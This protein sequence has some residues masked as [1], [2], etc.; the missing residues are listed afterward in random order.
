[1]SGKLRCAVVGLGVGEQHAQ[2][3]NAFEST[4]LKV[5]C[6]IDP[7]KREKFRGASFSNFNQIASNENIDLVS[8]ASFDDAHYEQVMACL[9]N[10]KHV[11]VEKPLCRTE[12]ELSNI[13]A[14]WR[15]K[16]TGLASNLVLRKAP[17]F[18]W[19]KEIIQSGGLGE[20]YS[21]DGDY[22]YGRVHKITNEWRSEVKDYSVMAGGGI[23]LIDLMMML[24]RKR[25][26]NVQSCAN[27][28][29]TQGTPFKYPDFHSSTF[30][31]EGSA[32]GRVTANFGC[33]HRHHHVIRVFGTKGTFIYD[34]RGAR[35]HWSR[36]EDS[37]PEKT[38]LNAKPEGKGVLIPDFVKAILENKHESYA[39]REFDLMSVVLA[40]DKALETEKTIEIRYLND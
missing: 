7:K 24:M 17:L 22:L 31:F 37:E 5:V 4:E 38:N 36:D 39:R 40:S 10:K 30:R 16:R 26:V 34:D 28:I 18:V 1:M 13:Y 23:H 8:I 14:L 2:T 3:Y 19:L 33:V 27:K 25:P 29:A 11:F 9:K 12:E 15:Q 20:V 21:F 35:I 32:I 6:D